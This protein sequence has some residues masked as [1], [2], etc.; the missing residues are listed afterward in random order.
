MCSQHLLALKQLQDIRDELDEEN[1]EQ[2]RK[3]IECNQKIKELQLLLESSAQHSPPHPRS[4]SDP[5]SMAAVTQDTSVLQKRATHIAQ[6]MNP[7]EIIPHLFEKQL[8]TQGQLDDLHSLHETKA[9]NM[10]I[11]QKVSSQG[12]KGVSSFIECLRATANEVP[13]HGDLANALL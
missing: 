8:L 11:V 13:A 3:L 5:Q 10:Y 1:E 4:C 9:K 12:H 2:A 7:T 6:Y